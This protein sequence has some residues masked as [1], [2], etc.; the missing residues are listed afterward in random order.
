M[1]EFFT[2]CEQ[3]GIDT[4]VIGSHAAW[5]NALGERHGA[6]L[7]AAWDAILQEH[8]GHGVV[9]SHRFLELALAAAL[10]AKNKYLTTVPSYTRAIC[11]WTR[12]ALAYI[13]VRW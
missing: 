7:Q 12:F 10:N 11:V 2:M 1:N 8:S 5:Q 13:T 9:N 4:K 3:L 6:I